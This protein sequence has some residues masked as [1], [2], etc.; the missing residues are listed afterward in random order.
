MA[1]QLKLQQKMSQQLVMTPQLQQAIK[2]LQLGHLEMAEELRKEL[3]ENPVLEE[4]GDSGDDGVTGEDLG[5]DASPRENSEPATSG[6]EAD[7]AAKANNELVSDMINAEESQSTP[8][9]TAKEVEKDVDWDNYI[10]NYEY[11]LPATAISGSA[12]DLP[13]IEATVSAQTSL[14]EHLRFQ[15]QM[16]DLSE[17]ERAIAVLLIEEIDE[18]GYLPTDAVDVVFDELDEYGV[19]RDQIETVVLEVQNLE[20]VG[21]ASF[22]VRDCLL[23]QVQMMTNPSPIAVQIIDGFLE[24]IEKRQF[25][26]ISKKLKVSMDQ[27]GEAVKFIAQLEPRPGRAYSTKQAQYI[28][29]DIYVKKIVLDNGETEWLITHNEEGIPKLRISSYYRDAMKGSN[30]S[31]K[32]YLQDKMRSAAW[33][34]RSIHMRQRTLHKVMESILKFQKSFFEQGPTHLKPL[35]LKDVADDVEMHESTISRVTTNKYVHTP[36]GIFE[37]KYFFNSSINR[38]GGDTIASESVRNRI[39][40]LISQENPKKPLSDQAIVKMLQTYD[41]KIARR[42]VAKYREMLK[43]PPSSKRKQVF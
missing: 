34:I 13:S 21:V 26:K 42:T 9:P 15:L 28:S 11:S 35:I 31:D 24:E 14:I 19:T 33:L 22:S 43:I 20:P 18:A 37:L 36:R 27:V 41:I 17:V 29:P 32:D 25:Q 4:R 3:E 8:E 10:D 38:T 1:I 2:L 5:L 30:G 39:Q 12:D 16:T 6:N 7:A 23:K 40:E